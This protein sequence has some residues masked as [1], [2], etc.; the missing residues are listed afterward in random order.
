MLFALLPS[1]HVHNP[2]ALHRTCKCSPISLRFIP[3][4]FFSAL[5]HIDDGKSL[6]E[7]IAFACIARCKQL[8]LIRHMS[9]KS[10]QLPTPLTGYHAAY[11]MREVIVAKF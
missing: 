3:R 6:L 4:L 8:G 9:I 11:R 5:R 7:R 2:S 1:R 10:G